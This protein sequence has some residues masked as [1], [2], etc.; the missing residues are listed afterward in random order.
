MFAQ[1]RAFDPSIQIALGRFGS[2]LKTQ[3][4]VCKKHLPIGSRGRKPLARSRRAEEGSFLRPPAAGESSADMYAGGFDF[5]LRLEVLTTA[6]GRAPL[7]GRSSAA[8]NGIG[9]VRPRLLLSS[10]QVQSEC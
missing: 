8:Q 4:I 5:R 6:G 3:H 7:Q 9:P 2:S 10:E 1:P